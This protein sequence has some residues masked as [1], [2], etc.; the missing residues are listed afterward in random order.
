M[1][2]CLIHCHIATAKHRI[3][4]VCMGVGGWGWWQA[5]SAHFSASMDEGRQAWRWFPLG[6][7]LIFLDGAARVRMPGYSL[8][9]GDPRC[10]GSATGT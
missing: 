2:V 10:P 8:L 4:H 6:T 5:G 7:I 1:Y 3:L 9:S